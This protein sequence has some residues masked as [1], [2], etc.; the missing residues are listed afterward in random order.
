MHKKITPP[1]AFA[2]G[3]AF[4]MAASCATAPAVRSNDIVIADKGSVEGIPSPAWVQVAVA[5][6]APNLEKLQEFSGSI[7]VVTSFESEKLSEAQAMANK[8]RPET[9]MGYFLSL[10]V[11]EILKNA[12]VPA[13]DFKT[14][15]AYREAFE[16]AVAEALYPEFKLGPDW[17][18]KFQ[19]A[20][21]EGK[22]G[23]EIFRVVKLWTVDKKALEKKFASL[24]AATHEKAPAL[25]SSTRARNLIENTLAAEL[26]GR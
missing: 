4:L 19:T 1:L 12:K 26:Y 17:W 11:R 10:R 9:E 20:G 7:V 14:Y 22:P 25:P 16:D 5:G 6:D 8:T 13:Q 23:K 2:I 24:L 18:V 15:S 3:L 21:A